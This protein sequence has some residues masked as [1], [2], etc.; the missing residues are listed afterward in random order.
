[1][2]FQKIPGLLRIPDVPGFQQ[3]DFIWRGTGSD[4][5]LFAFAAARSWGGH[6]IV[7]GGNLCPSLVVDGSVHTPVFTDIN[8]HVFWQGRGW[9][10]R[11]KAYG[12]V[13]ARGMFPGYEPVENSEWRDGGYVWEGDAFYSFSMPPSAPGVEIEMEPRGSIYESGGMKTMTALWPRWAAA[14]GEF[15]VYEG[16]DGKSGTKVLGLPQFRGNGET[17]LRSLKK[18]GGHFSYGRIHYASGKWVIGEAGSPGGWHEGPE[19][20]AGGAVEFRFM[21]PEGSD[22]QGADIT[23][24]FDRYVCGGETETAYLGSVA[25]W[26]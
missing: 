9:I 19:P 11:T 21:R 6:V 1:M 20:S 12:W 26:R 25:T 17:F 2:S 10:Y 16:A 24:S 5:G 13:Y 8:G 3:P 14:G 4:E 22:A 15:G 18:D 23:V 7:D